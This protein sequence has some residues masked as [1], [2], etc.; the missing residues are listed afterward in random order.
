VSRIAGRNGRIYLDA[1]GGGAASPL[2]FQAK[3]SLSFTTDKYDVT[4]LGD[5]N[6]TYVAGLA[7]A[8]GTFSG[9][10][11]NATVQTYTGAVDGVAR[12]FYLYPDTTLVTQYFFGT[13][14]VDMKIDADVQ[15]AVA[16]SSSW[17]SASSIAKVG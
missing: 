15:G 7:D 5:S 8:S 3:W 12:K 16:V 14:F 9:F 10:Y 17:N 1:P 4:A 6:K 13:V 11:D 2:P